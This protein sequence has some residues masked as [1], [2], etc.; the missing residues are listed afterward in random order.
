MNVELHCHLDGSMRVETVMELLQE[1]GIFESKEHL[2]KLLQVP[3]DCSSL[4]EYLKRFDLPL[5]C[6]Q[7]AHGLKRAAYELVCDA[8]KEDV[9]YIEVRFAPML[10]TKL[11][12]TGKEAIEAVIQGL[13]LG[14]AE[15]GTYASAIVCAMRHHSAEINLEML[16]AAQ[17]F[18][19]RGVCALDLAGDESRYPTHLFRDLF[20]EAKRIHMP[21][22]IHSGECGSVENVREAIALGAARIGHGIALE[23]STELRRL[24]AEKRIGIEMCPTSNLQ[25]KAVTDLSNYP[26]KQ[27][28][29]EE[30][31]VSINTDNRTVSGTTM[32]RETNLARGVLGLTEEELLQC[33]RNA[34]ETSFASESVKRELISSVPQ[35]HLR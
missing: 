26:M 6:L 14:E 1:Q 12:L 20:T 22:T 17:D 19:G 33:T 32:E 16:H 7:T 5:Q 28:L 35:L 9:K 24:C 4:T 27:F 21:F 34:I 8:A 13:Q 25:T 30:L 18:L 3:Q 15:T 10:S 11:G 2:T 31:P 23:K 29:A